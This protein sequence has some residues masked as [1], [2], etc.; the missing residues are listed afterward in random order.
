MRRR[1][2]LVAVLLLLGVLAWSS[3]F[4]VDRTEYVY[5]TQFGR[6]V[7][8]FDGGEEAGPHWK[9]PWPV[10]SVQRLERRLQSFDLPEAELLTHDPTG[11]TIDRTLTLDAYVCWR[12]AD[13]DAVDR[14]LRTV[15]TA[16]QAQVIIRQRIS[17]QLGAAI[18]AM[19]LDDLLSTEP[20]RV[21]RQREQLRQRLLAPW[22]T[23]TA[24]ADSYEY[25]IEIVDIRLRRASHPPQVREAIFN[26]IK[27][28]RKRKVADYESE[29]RK[30]ASLIASESEQR[31]SRLLADARAEEK[32]VREGAEIEADRLRNE[33]HAKDPDF[34][35]FLKKLDEYQ[36][37][38][39]DGKTML[40]L[41]SHRELFD[42]LFQPPR[43]GG[44]PAPGKAD[45]VSTAPRLPPTP[46]G[47][48]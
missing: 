23:W 29:G 42:L 41:S 9:W 38:L 11:Q 20:G 1:I 34:Y 40:L 43:P 26:R 24:D 17:S 30:Q 47:G 14:F 32:K 5:L 44:S 21:D 4:T 27:S 16:D 12:I 10:Q 39:G 18:G 13:K 15:G 37:I 25:G 19:E 7:A 33:A 35:V 2:L 3:F 22:Q 28:E 46:Q 36:R 6:H 8:T 31:V 48:P 45:G